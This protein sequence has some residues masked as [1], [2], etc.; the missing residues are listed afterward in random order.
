MSV[1]ERF[2][3]LGDWEV[4]LIPET[5]LSI[6]Q[7]IEKW[8]SIIITPSRIPHFEAMGSTEIKEAARYRGPLLE[9]SEDRTV[10]RGAGMLYYLGNANGDGPWLE[11]WI[12][13]PS[14]WSEHMAVMDGQYSFSGISRQAVVDEPAA[15]W[16]ISG[17]SGTDELPH[18]ARER[19]EF[20]ADVLGCE[21]YLTPDEKFYSGGANSDSMFTVTTPEV[22]LMRGESGRD[23]DLIGLEITDWSYTTDGWDVA[24]AAVAATSGGSIYVYATNTTQT[25]NPPNPKGNA[26]P[27]DSSGTAV[28]A[29]TGQYVRYEEMS[30]GT[31]QGDA[32]ARAQAIASTLGAVLTG[33]GI[34]TEDYGNH[35]LEVSVNV[36]DPHRWMMPG[37]YLYAF[38]PINKIYD[39]D[40]GTTYHGLHIHP[41]K[42]RLF[43]MTW[44][45]RAGMGVYLLNADHYG[46]Y[47]G[48]LIID[49]TD[50]VEWEDG[51]CTLEV[52]SP[53]RSYDQ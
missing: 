41:A 39:E 44:P 17:S 47:S 29:D 36:Y 9:I 20:L 22:I 8:D 2:M 11:Q 49:L 13:T 18:I 42:V 23:I 5:P 31:W 7:A 40:N 48:D 37:D 26:Y 1:S 15:K 33:V 46:S 12:V 10:L 35:T 34:T 30:S 52:G 3:Q 43:G 6:R 4:R 27:A 24:G 19:L 38:D 32:T 45:I 21:Y 51:D 14:D 50:Y 25:S 53:R 16:P 28:I